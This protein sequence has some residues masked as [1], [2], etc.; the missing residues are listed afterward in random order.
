MYILDTNPISILERR[1]PNSDK[2]VAHLATVDASEVYV[3]V[4]S[5][6]REE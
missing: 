3:T 2:L 6:R 4:I 1:G 5:Y